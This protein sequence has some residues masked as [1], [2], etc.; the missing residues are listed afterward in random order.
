[1]TTLNADRAA[2]LATSLLA[3]FA[4][5]DAVAK[6]DQD[7]LA[8]KRA[9]LVAELALTAAKPNS[10]KEQAGLSG[11]IAELDAQALSRTLQLKDDIRVLDIK[12]TKR[13]A[14]NLADLADKRA[15]DLQAL[16]SQLQAQKMPNALIGL[17]SVEV[18]K[19][20]QALTEE[21]AAR[22]ENQANIIGG[23]DA[24]AAEAATM[25]ASAS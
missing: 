3:E 19:F 17:S 10:K 24:R 7:A 18:N 21:A 9:L 14:N 20:N 15:T 1:M 25:R 12:D 2:G 16:Q 8:R 13:A 23:N 22:L 5:A 4:Y 11:A 6:L